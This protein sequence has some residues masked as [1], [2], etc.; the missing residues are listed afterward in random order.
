[1]RHRE[2]DIF[3]FGGLEATHGSE[4]TAFDEFT[5]IWHG[6]RIDQASGLIEFDGRW[7]VPELRRLLTPTTA[8]AP[9]QSPYTLNGNDPLQSGPSFDWAAGA[10]LNADG[11]SNS[12]N[13][14]VG[15]RY[16]YL[17]ENPG[18][19]VHLGLDLAGA[20]LIVGAPFDAINSA[21]NLAEGDNVNATISGVAVIPGLGYLATGG[22]ARRWGSWEGLI[23]TV[24]DVEVNAGISGYLTA[25]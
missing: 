5:G 20:F 8:T 22:Q 1:M 16:N 10:S 9:G 15:T 24:E 14:G 21:Y 7:Y 2:Y 18:E 17:S 13:R 6:G 4:L 19:A 11:Y 23:H 3:I 12:F 25:E